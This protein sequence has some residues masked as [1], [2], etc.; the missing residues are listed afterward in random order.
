MH[1][2]FLSTKVIMIIGACVELNSQRMVHFDKMIFVENLTIDYKIFTFF[3]NI[4]Y[5]LF[6][7][8]CAKYRLSESFCVFCY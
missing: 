2:R 7:T 6:F 3:Y 8:F 4:D 5:R 1:D